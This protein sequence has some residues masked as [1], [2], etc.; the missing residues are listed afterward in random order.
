MSGIEPRSTVGSYC[1]SHGNA[2][3]FNDGTNEPYC[4]ICGRHGVDLNRPKAGT[5]LTPEKMAG[6]PRNLNLPW[7]TEPDLPLDEMRQL[8][9]VVWDDGSYGEPASTLASYVLALLGEPPFPEAESDE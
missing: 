2:H 5:T 7:R 3:I 9:R 6:N 4:L 8:A 1:P